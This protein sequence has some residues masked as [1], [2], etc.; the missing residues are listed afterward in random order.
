MSRT[1]RSARSPRRGQLLGEVAERQLPRRVG[2]AVGG[3]PKNWVTLR[4][5]TSANSSRRSYDDTRPWGPTARSSEQVSAPEPTPAS[6]TSRPGE[7][8]GQ[9]HDLGGVLGVDDRGAARHRDDE[10]GEQRPEDE[11]LAA[12]RGGDGEPLLAADQLVVVEVAPVGEEPLARLQLEVVAPALAVGQPHP[13]AG[14]QRAAVDAGPRLGRDVGCPGGG[15][16]AASGS[17]SVTVVGLPEGALDVGGGQHAV[18]RAVV[19][20]Q[21]VLGGGVRPIAATRS[22]PAIVAGSV[23]PSSRLRATVDTATHGRRS[24]GVATQGGL[25]DQADGP[26]GAGDGDDAAGLRL[27][28]AAYGL[29]Q[30]QVLRDREGTPGQPAGDQR[31]AAGGGCAPS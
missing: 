26:A 10:L 21:E 24:S 22:S 31:R 20:E 18:D 1:I 8:V 12:G 16:V 13:L 17:C 23:R 25:V 14:P 2:R 3:V 4:R 28:G 27:V 5:A 7:D 11:V 30:R 9:R 6:T 29:G 15:A 19:L